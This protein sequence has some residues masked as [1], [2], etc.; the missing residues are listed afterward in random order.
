MHTLH[1]LS[2]SQ[3][4]LILGN[5]TDPNDVVPHSILKEIKEE[6]PQIHFVSWDPTEELPENIGK[7]LTLIDVVK[8]ITQM[9]IFHS[10]EEFEHSPR[11]TVHDFDLPIALK[12]LQKL[13]KVEKITI[14]GIPSSSL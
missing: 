3:T 12:L 7:D 8:G 11:N 1:W 4:V 6:Y 9:T 14:I 10:L 5:N 2:N 13:K